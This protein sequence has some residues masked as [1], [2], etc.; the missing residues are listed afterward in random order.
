MTAYLILKNHPLHLG[1]NGPDI[2]ITKMMLKI[3]ER[4]KKSTISFE[5]SSK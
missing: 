2:T 5:N 1:Q 4:F 3:Q